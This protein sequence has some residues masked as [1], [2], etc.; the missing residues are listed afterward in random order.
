MDSRRQLAAQPLTKLKPAE[1][2]NARPSYVLLALFQSAPP[3]GSLFAVSASSA[4]LRLN[5]PP[6]KPNDICFDHFDSNPFRSP[7]CLHCAP[8]PAGSHSLQSGLRFPV[9][10]HPLTPSHASLIHRFASSASL[11]LTSVTQSPTNRFDRFDSDPVLRKRFPSFRSPV[12]GFP[13]RM[14]Q[15]APS[16]HP[17]PLPKTR[18]FCFDHFDPLGFAPPPTLSDPQLPS[19]SG[20]APFDR[21]R[22][23]SKRSTSKR[24]V[25]VLAPG[26]LT[27]DFRAFALIR[28]VSFGSSKSRSPRRTPFLPLTL[29]SRACAR[30][31]DH[32]LFQSAPPF[33]NLFAVP[34]SSASLRLNSPPAKPNDIRFDRF[35]LLNALR[36]GADHEMSRNAPRGGAHP[37]PANAPRDSACPS[38]E[39]IPHRSRSFN[40]YWHSGRS[41]NADRMEAGASTRSLKSRP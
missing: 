2:P 20:E 15:P 22:A 36:G 14:I 21:L 4:S 9:S 7:V 39:R 8:A 32:P 16:L 6:A 23:L 29:S 12:S 28:F 37:R 5:P 25:A 17:P 30:L 1:Y 33:G 35:D 13:F 10:P 3:F 38:A 40:R 26:E 31:R 19:L 24:L 18:T 11:R 27:S 34:A 41:R